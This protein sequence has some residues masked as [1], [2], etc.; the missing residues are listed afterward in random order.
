MFDLFLREVASMAAA[1]TL[2]K[3]S[4]RD[5]ASKG[6]TV[7]RSAEMYPDDGKKS[8]PED[9]AMAMRARFRVKQEVPAQTPAREIVN[10]QCS[11]W[12]RKEPRFLLFVSSASA[13][14]AVIHFGLSSAQAQ[15]KARI[16]CSG[17]LGLG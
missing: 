8:C 3:D 15:G 14:A 4:V 6:D 9:M 16:F 10:R 5:A 12:N 7:A 17:T 13:R 1:A 11:W 2:Y